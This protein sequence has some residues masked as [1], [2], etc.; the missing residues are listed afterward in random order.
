MITEKTIL[1]I[2]RL[3]QIK[4]SAEEVGQYQKDLSQALQYFKMIETISTDGV[5]P[6]VTP[7]VEEQYLR[8]DLP[9]TEISVEELLENAPAKV[10]NLFKVPPV[11]G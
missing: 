6:M 3:A 10:G 9:K 4:I 2:A 11:V 7:I 5:E 1:D 8:E